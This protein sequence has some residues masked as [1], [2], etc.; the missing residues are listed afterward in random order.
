MTQIPKPIP[1][2]GL[3]P[4]SHAVEDIAKQ[5]GFSD[6]PKTSLLLE[7]ASAI[8]KGELQVRSSETGAPSVVTP[9]T[10]NPSPYVTINDVNN[11]LKVRG[12]TYTWA[13]QNILISPQ[14]GPLLEQ[15][16]DKHDGSS[17]S[18]TEPEDGNV[19]A[20]QSQQAG[21]TRKV[22]LAFDWPGNVNLAR[23]ISDIPQW[24]ESARTMR[25]RRGRRGSALWN[26]ALLAICLHTEKRV[27]KAALE[28]HITNHFP[29][30]LSDWE[31]AIDAVNT[32]K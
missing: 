14:P 31:A 25:G 9:N 26:P 7:M 30:Y 3:Y 2:L 28:R 6:G 23:L 12:F 13:P 16:H 10:N 24:L 11:W 20:A 21:L 19:S 4:Y 5:M 15:A 22:V 1:K 32:G 27:P 18:N 8:R 29:D 17:P